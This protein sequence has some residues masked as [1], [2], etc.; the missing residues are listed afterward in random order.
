MTETTL[1]Q[2]IAERRKM[3]SLSQEAF[4]E[5]MGVSRQA[6]FKWE[7]DASVPEVDKLINMSRLFGVSVGW[8]L[9]EE[10]SEHPDTDDTPE[11]TEQIMLAFQLPRAGAGTP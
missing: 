6:A 5:K 2:R 1:G 11:L 4:G 10:E 9:G 7:S 8:L 3:L